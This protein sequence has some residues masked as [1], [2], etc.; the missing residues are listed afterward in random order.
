[1]Q[2]SQEALGSWIY[3]WW[4]ESKGRGEGGNNL[5]ATFDK[6]H[7]GAASNLSVC[8]NIWMLG[9]AIPKWMSDLKVREWLQLVFGSQDQYQ[10]Y[11]SKVREGQYV[12]ECHNQKSGKDNTS[13]SVTIK[14]QGR[15]IRQRVSQSKVRGGG[16]NCFNEPENQFKGS[17]NLFP[18]F[19]VKGQ[20]RGNCRWRSESNVRGIKMF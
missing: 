4:S 13:A 17:S 6:V 2:E 15:T 10:P 16:L 18:G 5:A 19:H 9:V 3:Q 1:M 8:N 7:P 14:S 20:W 12:S 11:S